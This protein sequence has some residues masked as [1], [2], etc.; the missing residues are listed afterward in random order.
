MERLKTLIHDDENAVSPVIGVILMVAITVILAA[1]IASFVIGLGD[2]N[3]PAPTPQFD[4]EQEEQY[5]NFTKAGGDDF[6]VQDAEITATITLE[7]T[8]SDVTEELEFDVTDIN[9]SADS[10]TGA[11]T[12]DSNDYDVEY[13]VSVLPNGEMTA[14]DDFNFDI[15]ETGSG[16][17]ADDEDIEIS[18]WDVEMV[19][20]PSGEDTEIIYESTA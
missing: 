5:V 2:Q 16:Y 19:W 20:A 11:V 6:E 9:D 8:T 3:D 10:E 1:V 17:N 4:I 18:G 12:F 7:N 14:G 13:N 15:I